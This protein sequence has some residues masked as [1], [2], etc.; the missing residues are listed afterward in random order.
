MHSLPP[1]IPNVTTPRLNLR[2][3][4]HGDL[5]DYHREI[6]GDAEVMHFLVGRSPRK[7]EEVPARIDYILNHWETYNY[8]IWAV[9][10]R[11]TGAFMG[12]AGL[13][14]IEGTGDTEIA[15]AL[16]KRYWSRGYAT[17]AARAVIRYAFEVVG[18]EELWGVAYVE[19]V[20]SQR[21]MSKAG[22]QYLGVTGRFYN[23]Q[24]ATFRIDRA[25][26]RLNAAAY[27]PEAPET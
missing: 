4:M 12:Q 11:A 2:G 24:A 8:G 1:A 19:N 20:G 21:V 23:F 9:T 14:V 15:Y 17:E 22:M 16:G 13:N 3:F 5:E 7:L 6:Q 27:R 18:L 10:E 26:Y 25:Q